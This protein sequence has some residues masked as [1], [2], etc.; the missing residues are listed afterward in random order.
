MPGSAS[1]FALPGWRRKNMNAWSGGPL[2]NGPAKA[3]KPPKPPLPT[4]ACRREAD[5]TRELYVRMQDKV[6]EAGLA[7]GAH[8]ADIWVVDEARPPAK[9]AAPNLPL[10]MA[11]TLF[12]GLWIAAAAHCSG[13]HPAL[14]VFACGPAGADRVC[15]RRNPVRRQAPTPSTSGLPTGVAKIPQTSDNKATPNP[16]DAPARLDR[17][18]TEL[19]PDIPG[20][21]HLS[22]APIAAP[23]DP[24]RPARDR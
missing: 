7:A 8:G 21:R 1:S 20:R 24:G 17:P 2:R 9:P 16:K 19:P 10:Y 11:I 5:S 13:V 14:T 23:I 12:A 4:R 18:G 22:S 3:R 15:R 6:E